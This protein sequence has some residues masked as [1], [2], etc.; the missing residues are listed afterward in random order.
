MAIIQPSKLQTITYGIASLTILA[1]APLLVRDILPGLLS[2]ATHEPLA[3]V[4]LALAGV[5]CPIYALAQRRPMPD[6]AKASMLGAAF[7]FWAAN[8][9]WP[10]HPEATLLNDIAVALFVMDVSLAILG[11]PS[12]APK[13]GKSAHGL[14]Y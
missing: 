1:L 7:F 6:L 9:L 10:N 8:Q 13:V 4:P 3:A 5:A 12:S 11:W 14:Q 2:H